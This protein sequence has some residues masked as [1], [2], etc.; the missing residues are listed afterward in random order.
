V[1]QY[2][3]HAGKISLVITDMMMPIM[4]GATAIREIKRI[5]RFA[6]ILVV[7]GL[8]VDDDVKSGVSG[9]V[10]KPYTA[11]ELAQKVRDALDGAVARN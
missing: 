10:T 2:A 9:F 6:K 5:N 11:P 4:D 1:A 7:S 8:D 3:K